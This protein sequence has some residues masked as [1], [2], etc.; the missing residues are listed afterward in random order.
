MRNSLLVLGR[1]AHDPQGVLATVY[2]LAEMSVKLRV[3][4]FRRVLYG[5]L[6]AASN[7]KLLIAIQAH[8][9]VW[10]R[11]DTFYDFKLTLWHEPIISWAKK[12]VSSLR[13]SNGTTTEIW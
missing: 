4:S 8:S 7:L 5:K 6:F 3:D 12:D 13:I 9:Q 1:L 2:R 11:T 10:R